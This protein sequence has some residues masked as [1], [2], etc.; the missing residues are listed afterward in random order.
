MAEWPFGDTS[1]RIIQYILYVTSYV[2]IYTLIAVSAVRFI[3]IVYGSK[4][5]LI[6][7]KRNIV[8]VIIGIWVCF[9]LAKIPILLVHG[10]SVNPTLNRTE[11][12]VSGKTEGQELFASFFVFAYALPLAIIITL[13]VLIVCHLSRHRQERQVLPLVASGEE[14][15]RHVTK[16]VLLVV[17][18]FAV[19]WLPMHI[20]ILIGYYGQLPDSVAY[21]ILLIVWH[22]LAFS[23][24]VLNPLI[25]NCFSKDFHDSFKDVFLCK[26]EP[27]SSSL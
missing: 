12:I 24:S 17:M 20:H 3:T 27:Q 2:T 21:T 14:R 7:H 15:S 16:I 11:C 1:C 9:L 5:K 19:C 18:V 26:K 25:Y 8:F 13:Y 6:R 23:N 22:C 4:C 10:V